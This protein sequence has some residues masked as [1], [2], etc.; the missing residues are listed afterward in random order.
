[1][2]AGKQRN[3]IGWGAWLVIGVF[4]AL[5]I[6]ASLAGWGVSHRG[7]RGLHYPAPEEQG[8]LQR[9]PPEIPV[10]PK[11]LN[12]DE[13]KTYCDEWPTDSVKMRLGGVLQTVPCLDVLK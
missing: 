13:A 2:S 9:R 12:W 5:S 7:M 4:V 10:K 3:K 8:V 1:M 6:L 11:E